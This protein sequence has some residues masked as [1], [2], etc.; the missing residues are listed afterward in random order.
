MVKTSSA[1]EIGMSTFADYYMGKPGVDEIVWKPYPALRTAWA[2]MMRDE[3][4]FLYEVSQDTVEFVQGETSVNTFKFLRPYVFGVVFNSNRQPFKSRDVRRALNFAVNRQLVV[5]QALKGQGIVAQSPVYPD[6]WAFDQSLP[7][8][9]Y[10]PFR[11]A[12]ILE[13]H[14]KLVRAGVSNNPSPARFR[15][16]CLLIENLA[17]WERMA[18][19][20]QKQLFEIGVDMRLETLPATVFNERVARGEFDALFLEL[21]SGR[22]MS[23][24]YIFWHSAGALNSFGYRNDDVDDALNAIRTA[25]D[26]DT[27]RQSV[28]RFQR[29]V[30]G[31]P[32]AIFLAWGQTTRAVSSRFEVPVAPNND[33]LTSVSSWSPSR[34]PRESKR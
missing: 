5:D 19:I 8:Y 18:L 34:N 25:P 16:T 15:F 6:H 32:P 2:G 7:G 26:D 12:A 13:E 21:I 27:Y 1:Q 3:I 11:A 29:S 23:K 24:P 20:V 4:D 22:S 28:S 14:Y 9:S 30:Q 10:D 33:I 31:D 17:H